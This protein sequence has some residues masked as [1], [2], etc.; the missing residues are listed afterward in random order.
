MDPTEP[1]RFVYD[2]LTPAKPLPNRRER[3]AD[4]RQLARQLNRGRR[5]RL[6][7]VQPD[8]RETCE[9]GQLAGQCTECAKRTGTGGC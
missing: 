8:N 5:R 2:A 7:A 9:H 4:A 3:R 6:V 1:D